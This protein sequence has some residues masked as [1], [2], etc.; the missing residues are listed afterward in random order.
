MKEAVIWKKEGNAIRCSLCAHRCLIAEGSTGICQVRQ[1]K[2]GKL[3][4][5]IYGRVAAAHVDPIEKKPLYHFR[6][7]TLAYSIGTVGCNFSCSF[8]QNANISQFIRDRGELWGQERK[9]RD[10]VKAAKAEGC[11][12]IAYTYNEPTIFFEYA[13]D[14]ALLA[15]SEGISNVFVS[16]GFMT[17]EA[18]KAAKPWLDAANIDLK[19]FNDSFYK[20]VCGGMLEPV[21]E[22]LKALKKAGIWIEV[23][24]LVIPK[25]NDSDAELKQI[26]DFVAGELGKDVPWHISAF[27]PDYKMT[28]TDST[29]VKTLVKAHNIGCDAGLENIYIG[30]ADTDIGRDTLCPK[31]GELLVK[32]Q[33]YI[34]LEN[35]LRKGSC[36]SC[37]KEIAGQW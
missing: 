33:G 3:Y 20:H 18:V 28:A 34:V 16:N 2:K 10:I 32:R 25:E 23:T 22:S 17:P 19:S 30:N 36:P 35:R 9:P 21:L 24:T 27:H 37:G 8:C 1:N 29:P 12:S 14:C 11:A 7:S 15:K 13:Q 26:A 5:L 6:P 31:C 4:S